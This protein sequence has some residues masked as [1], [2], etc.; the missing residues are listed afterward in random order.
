MEKV[1]LM[2]STPNSGNTFHISNLYDFPD[3]KIGCYDVFAVSEAVVYLIGRQV[4][5]STTFHRT[6]WVYVAGKFGKLV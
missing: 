2:N 4:E 6:D 1:T 5:G 3:D